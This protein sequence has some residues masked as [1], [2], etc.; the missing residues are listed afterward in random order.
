MRKETRWTH[1]GEETETPEAPE[2]KQPLQE[3][4]PPEAGLALR[5]NRV[6]LLIGFFAI[7]VLAVL[8]RMVDW[9]ILRARTLRRSLSPNERSFT[10]ADRG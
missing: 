4:S 8:I 9:Q 10:R 7:F 1:F 3:Q 5:A 6:K 2:T